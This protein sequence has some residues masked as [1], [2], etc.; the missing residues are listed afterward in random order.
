MSVP[1]SSN[2]LSAA[3]LLCVWALKCICF[4]FAIIFAATSPFICAIPEA[5][6]L[7]LLPDEEFPLE[8]GFLTDFIGL[9]PVLFGLGA[10]LFVSTDRLLAVEGTFAPVL[11]SCDELSAD[12]A[13]CALLSRRSRSVSH[14]QLR[15]TSL[16]LG[17]PMLPY[18]PC[19]PAPSRYSSHA[20]HSY[21]LTDSGVQRGLKEG[22]GAARCHHSAGPCRTH[23]QRHSVLHRCPESHSF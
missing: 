16:R 3:S 7:E 22:H 8:K 17:Q 5:F 6:K 21:S 15:T 23:A 14:W 20:L 10:P 13:P 11:R 19:R 1:N 2:T 12:M 9:E 18:S 4:R